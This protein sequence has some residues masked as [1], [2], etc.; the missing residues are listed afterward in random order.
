M[1]WLFF[2]LISPSVKVKVYVFE[3]VYDPSY[4]NLD[5]DD[6]DS[7]KVYAGKVRTLI[8]KCLNVPL[9]D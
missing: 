3:D 5:P 9:E 1:E 8:S 6:E 7:W 4:L 2:S